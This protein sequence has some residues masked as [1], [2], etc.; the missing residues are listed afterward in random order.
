MFFH[1]HV[2]HNSLNIYSEKSVLDKGCRVKQEQLVKTHFVI[3]NLCV[4]FMK[5]FHH[6]KY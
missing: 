3:R 2:E 6:G 5:M 4:W 1:V